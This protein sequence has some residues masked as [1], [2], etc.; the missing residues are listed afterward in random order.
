MVRRGLFAGA[1]AVG[2]SLAACDDATNPMTTEPP[3][4]FGIDAGGVDSN[5]P[6]PSPTE[7]GGAIDGSD[8][9]TEPP[10]VIG[11]YVACTTG[12]DANTGKSD[13][14]LKTLAKAATVATS[15]TTIVVLDGT[16]SQD[17]EPAFNKANG[18]V[19]LPDGVS[20]RAATP[21]G[22]TFTGVNGYRSGGITFA[23]SGRIA[24]VRFVTFGHA[25]TAS[26]GNVTVEGVTF[27]DIGQGFPI[28]AMGTSKVTVKPGGVQNYIG[29]NQAN[30]AEVSG[31]GEL[32]MVGGTI[33]GAKDNGISGAAQL[34]V[35]D[36]GKLVL[37][38]TTLIDATFSGIAVH[39]A[40]TAIVKNKSV[41]DTVGSNACCNQ[42]A[43][44]AANTA[45]IEVIDSTII[46]A[47]AS[48]IVLRT[49]TPAVKLEKATVE[50]ANGVAV[51]AAIYSDSFPSLQIKDSTIKGNRDGI[52]L[53]YAATLD[54]Q[55]SSIIDNGSA[56]SCGRGITMNGG[57][58]KNTV[59]IRSTTIK[60]NCNGGIA[61]TGGSVDSVYDFGTKASAGA[62][63]F[64]LNNPNAQPGVANLILRFPAGA[65]VSAVGNTW[66][67]GVQGAAPAGNVTPP[68][69]QYAVPG[70]ETVLEVTGATSGANYL[71]GENAAATV[72][73][74][75]EQ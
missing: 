62:N 47:R 64:T 21:G 20:L 39:N 63:T 26:S 57:S 43:I 13:A 41:L 69:G 12:N 2:V 50:A 44:S 56:A 74:L 61:L 67:P 27:D 46:R 5:T 42:A 19:T 52:Y 49:G 15:G 60:N 35:R 73:R 11:A 14:P 4:G 70:G 7:D 1:I 10:E 33:R 9:S 72:L 25:I 68:P 45:K 66:D 3:G 65:T 18:T 40:G 17:T 55:G 22:V 6:N 8:A 48:A 38:G 59:N 32:T 23:G 28:R 30:F 71:L 16:C 53:N 54:I 75:A 36:S 31:N 58:Q 29:T 24:G 34:M 51:S 37:D